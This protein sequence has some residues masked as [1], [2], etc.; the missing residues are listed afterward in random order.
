MFPHAY[1][2]PDQAISGR[3]ARPTPPAAHLA[4][5]P[6]YATTVHEHHTRHKFSHRT[7][8]TN[9]TGFVVPTMRRATAAARRAA[10]PAS[11]PRRR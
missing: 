7:I 3:H 5:S 6:T 11:S 10:P 1:A 4:V 9:D 2:H 8:A